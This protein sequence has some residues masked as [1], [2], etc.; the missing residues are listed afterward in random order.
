MPA[1][2]AHAGWLISFIIISILCIMSFVTVTFVI[3]SM[4]IANAVLKKEQQSAASLQLTPTSRIPRN[5]STISTHSQGREVVGNASPELLT[6]QNTLSHDEFSAT[7]SSFKFDV[8]S[9]EKAPLLGSPHS[10]ASSSN[11]DG[12]FNQSNLDPVRNFDITER[13]EMGQMATMFFPKHLITIFYICLALYLYGDL[14][15]YA[16][17][18]AKSLRDVTW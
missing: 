18:I 12:L 11:S 4:S 15:I 2:F 16:A 1:A 14:A 7:E 3:E 8:A 13:V 6:S 10:D 17:A 9:A 5:A